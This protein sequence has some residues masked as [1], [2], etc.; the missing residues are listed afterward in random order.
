MATT[1][2]KTTLSSTYN[3]DWND[4]DHYHQILFNSGRALQAREL[5]QMQTIQHKEIAR[6]GKN[7]FKEGT[8]T[9]DGGAVIN[10][11]YDFVQISSAGGNDF[12]ALPIGTILSD[13]AIQAKV[14]EEKE[15]V[16]Q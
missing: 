12:S 10:S 2:T 3:D 7:L 9:L 5:T 1:F 14:L 4:S 8:P 6:L 13:G 15:L 16:Y 11:K